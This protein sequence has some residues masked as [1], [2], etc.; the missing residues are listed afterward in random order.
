[1]RKLATRF[2]WKAVGLVL[3]ALMAGG[4]G[5]LTADT[6][7]AAAAITFKALTGGGEGGVSVNIYLPD[8]IMVHQG[9][10]VE[11]TNPYEEP[12]TV[13]I[14]TLPPG[15]PAEPHDVAVAASFDGTKAFSSGFITKG[16]KFS[17]TFKSLGVY[18]FNCLIHPGMEVDVFVLGPGAT[19]PTQNDATS[20]A[21][22]AELAKAIA[23][24]TKQ[25]A[26]LKVPAATKNADGSSSYTVV[27]P[28]GLPYSGSLVGVA[29]MKFVNS[30]LQ[31]GVG[32]SVTWVAESFV[33]HTVTF[34]P[35]SGPPA[36]INPFVNVIPPGSFD[37]SQYQ[38][39]IFGGV[40]AFSS[41]TKFSMTFPKA[42]TYSYICL[43]H[44]DQGMAGVIVV[45]PP[46][47]GAAGGGAITPPSTGDGGLLGTNSSAAMIYAGLVML[48]AATAAG[49]YVTV[50]R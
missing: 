29:V 28:P 36:V 14:G 12:H 45:G 13:S 1:M 43:L 4:A 15:D 31:I 39:A 11:W 27:T 18:T 37:G 20:A 33:P 40:P 24:G 30:R 17:V 41:T 9:D 8:Q 38:T 21:V 34:M 16:S 44:A 6:P 35:P 32:D 48:L 49:A 42:G 26:D 7:S 2:R 25:L 47:S 50:K 3:F 23:V 46:G 22:K 10:T 5:L 19:F